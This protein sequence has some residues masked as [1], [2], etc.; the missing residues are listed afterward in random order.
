MLVVKTDY[1]NE[2]PKS[3]K[4]AKVEYI[5]EEGIQMNFSFKKN[6]LGGYSNL[7]FILQKNDSNGLNIIE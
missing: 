2:L 6:G 4:P 5:E 3:F 1:E 7:G